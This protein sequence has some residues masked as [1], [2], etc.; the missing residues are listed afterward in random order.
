M[1]KK[2]AQTW[3]VWF[4]LFLVVQ[5]P[6]AGSVDAVELSVSAEV[7]L[8]LPPCALSSVLPQGHTQL[9]PGL[10]WGPGLVNQGG[11]GWSLRSFQSKP[12]WD[13]SPFS[14]RCLM[15]PGVLWGWIR[16]KTTSRMTMSI[17]NSIQ[18]WNYQA[19]SQPLQQ[20]QPL[21][22]LPWLGVPPFVV[23]VHPE[24]PWTGSSVFQKPQVGFSSP[25]CFPTCSA[26]PWGY[27]WRKAVWTRSLKPHNPPCCQPGWEQPPGSS[28]TLFE[29]LSC[30]FRRCLWIAEF[31][32]LCVPLL[33]DDG[34]RN[35]HCSSCG[36]ITDKLASSNTEMYF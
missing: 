14:E 27:T 6:Q 34:R 13:S 16:V 1:K 4:A 19:L 5:Q 10:F 18:R 28:G 31:I 33:S 20:L 26:W 15:L 3:E 35:S 2:R 7:Q 36:F 32:F 29:L 17:S 12:S 11:M 9:L 24:F 8:S 23:D 22:E 25:C 30:Y 21:P